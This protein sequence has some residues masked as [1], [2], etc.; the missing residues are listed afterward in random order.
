MMMMDLDQYAETVN[1]AVDGAF[2]ETADK[3]SSRT[4]K[5]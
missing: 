3:G 2:I 1:C 4:F 5:C